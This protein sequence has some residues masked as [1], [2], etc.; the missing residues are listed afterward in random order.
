MSNVEKFTPGND[1]V[2]HA[3]ATPHG[4]NI[5]ASNDAGGYE[6]VA[7][8]SYE[9]AVNRLDA[10]EYD[11]TPNIGYAIH[12]AVA[13][14]GARGWFDFTAQHNLTMW[15]WLIA[16]TFISEMKRENGTTTITEDDGKSSLVTFYSNGTEGIVV[17]PFAERLAMANNMEGAMIERYGIEQGTANAIVFYQAMIDTERGE[18]TPFGRETL[19]ELHDGFIADLNENGLPEMPAAH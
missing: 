13:D 1:D 3:E 7:L 10:G 14:G 2:L 5:M 15:R 4:L 9:S 16:A 8:I 19:A 12:F 17:Y 18:L 11:D 6:L